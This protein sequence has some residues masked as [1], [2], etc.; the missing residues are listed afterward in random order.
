MSRVEQIE[1]QII[2][3]G[4]DEFRALREWFEQYEAEV[5]DRQI[6]EDARSGKLTRLAKRA[7]RDYEA[8]R[9]T[10]L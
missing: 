9:T 6:E 8:G 10:K 3:L 2:A 5:W 7:L 1:Q 4:P